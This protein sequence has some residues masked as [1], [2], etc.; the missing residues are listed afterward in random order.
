MNYGTFDISAAKEQDEYREWVSN[1]TDS[2]SSQPSGTPDVYHN[3]G[4]IKRA[5]GNFNSENQQDGGW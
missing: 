2:N 3:G 5:D 1:N 4:I